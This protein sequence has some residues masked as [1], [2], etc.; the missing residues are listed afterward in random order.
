[1]ISDG[2]KLICG[3]NDHTNNSWEEPFCEFPRF[4]FKI[5]LKAFF[6]SRN[7]SF[8]GNKRSGVSLKW[9]LKICIKAFYSFVERNPVFMSNAQSAIINHLWQI[10]ATFALCSTL[11]PT[12]CMHFCVLIFCLLI[13]I[14]NDI[15]TMVGVQ[16]ACIQ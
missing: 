12:E 6:F 9:K 4:Q 1:M 15:V 5:K 2:S 7:C 16:C 13:E 10:N 3:T 11:W 14:E 8:F